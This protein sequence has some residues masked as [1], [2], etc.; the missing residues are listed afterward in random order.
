MRNSWKIRS[1]VVFG[2]AITGFMLVDGDQTAQ[3]RPQYMKAFMTSYEGLEEEAKKVKCGLCHGKKKSE[4]NK[5]GMAVGK[6][7]EKKNEKDAEKLAEALKTAE[8]ADSST[9]GKTFGDLIADGKL[10]E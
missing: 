6:G 8:K 7:L 10:P 3:A 1:A 4:R 2:L 9:E 5:Y